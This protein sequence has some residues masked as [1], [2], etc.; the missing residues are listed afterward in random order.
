MRFGELSNLHGIDLHR[1]LKALHALLKLLVPQVKEAL[2]PL[3]T[4]TAVPG[5]LPGLVIA[6]VVTEDISK[7]AVQTWR[8]FFLQLLPKDFFCLEVTTEITKLLLSLWFKGKHLL[9]HMIQ[10]FTF[11]V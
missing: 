5:Q 7:Q 2:G 3:S 9:T 1:A 6:A 10:N 11:N 8:F 4:G